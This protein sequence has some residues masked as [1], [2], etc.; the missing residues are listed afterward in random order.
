MHA[1]AIAVSTHMAVYTSYS[2]MLRGEGKDCFV[3]DSLGHFSACF[4]GFYLRAWQM[5][6]WPTSKFVKHGP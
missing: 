6:E 3:G 1:G 2:M 4:S 5:L